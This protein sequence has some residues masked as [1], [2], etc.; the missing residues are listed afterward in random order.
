VK[1]FAFRFERVL[2]TKRY[3]EEAKRTE[4]AVLMA[5]RLQDEQ[6]LLAVQGT[7]LDW[8]R[9]L[10]GRVEARQVISDI[11]RLA[12]YMNKLADDIR[13]IQDEL[14]RWDEQIEVKR[15]ELVEAK[16]ETTVLEKLKASDR[17]AYD[18]ALSDWEQKL[19]DEAAAGPYARGVR[20][21]VR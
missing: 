2:E 11:A 3:L 21:K 16:R 19:I 7:L 12:R 4:L 9:E 14:A 6:R 20:G 10:A 5:Q 1:R 13:R 8:Q 15:E 18:K 17:R